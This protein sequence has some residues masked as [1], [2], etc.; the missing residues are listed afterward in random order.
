MG[1][2]RRASS[3][4]GG[5]AARFVAAFLVAAI[6]SPL[7]PASA[8]GEERWVGRY[9]G[10]ESS[11][12]GAVA[13]VTSPNG[14]KVFVTGHVGEVVDGVLVFNYGTLA[15]DAATGDV[16]W[17][18]I[19]DGPAGWRD[20]VSAMAINP[21]GSR[22]FVTGSSWV[23][24]SRRFDYVTIAYRTT[25]GERLWTKHYDGPAG[26]DDGPIDVTAGLGGRIFVTGASRGNGTGYD[27][28][29]VAHSA[30]DGRRLWARYS[31]PKNDSARSVVASPDGSTVFVTGWNDRDE[32]SNDYVTL[33]YN[34]RTGDRLWLRGF[35]RD[36][37]SRAVRATVSPD[38][39]TVFVTGDST[40]KGILEDSRYVTLAYSASNG[41]RRWSAHYNGPGEG[42]YAES[43][44]VSPDGSKVFI[45]GWSE[46]VTTSWDYATV[47]YRA[48]T[49]TRLWVQRYDG[50]ASQFD[51]ASSVVVSEDGTRIYVTGASET[52]P[53]A[54][55]DYA[56]IAYGASKGKELWVARYDGPA[57]DRDG[58]SSIAISPD[59]SV[60]YVTG[61]SRGV[62]TG[63][64][65][66]ATVA[67]AA[68]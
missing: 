66:Y 27:Y 63:F 24:E 44:A 64:T 37:E 17:A 49:G 42:A 47:A 18:R 61:A 40:D 54:N 31:G 8:A 62:V 34:A 5:R 67:Y 53:L 59:G 21:N 45:T 11:Q 58:A 2:E 10:P 36:D 35:R 19:Y 14:S 65:D 4:F 56:T 43:I 12:D 28:A 6:L 57:K 30:S 51:G 41:K 46:G 25:T 13:V 60:V 38:G 48:R 9:N 26:H 29:T 50:G 23:G 52:G 16:L 3:A 55:Q 15:Y 20:D 39:S 32:T 68:K 1:P 33:A 7:E 22:V